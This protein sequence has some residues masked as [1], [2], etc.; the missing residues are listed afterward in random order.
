M[1]LG[2]AYNVIIVEYM[3]ML[4]HIHKLAILQKMANSL[5][6]CYTVF[7]NNIILTVKNVNGECHYTL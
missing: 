1:M 6:S 2:H 3:H 4:A 7:Y 5:A